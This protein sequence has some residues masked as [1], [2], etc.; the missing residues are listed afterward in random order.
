[1][2]RS[3]IGRVALVTGAAV[4]I[5]QAYARRLAEDGADVVIADRDAADETVDLVKAVGRRA[6]AVRCG[7]GQS[8]DVA[9]LARETQSCFGRCDILV[10]NAGI[11]PVQKSDEI[12]FE[13][14]RRVM[15]VNLDSQGPV[16][17]N[18]E[19]WKGVQ[20]KRIEIIGVEHHNDVRTGGCK[21]LLL[22]A[23]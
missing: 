12:T 18:G 20:E 14:W 9:A 22:C 11:Y 6:L 7:V 15:S 16:Y 17:A 19:D 4:G 2:A 5:G 21:L 23:K 1:M 8:S 13:D 3:Q 10:N